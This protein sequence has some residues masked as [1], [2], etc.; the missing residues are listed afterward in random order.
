[1]SDNQA[2]TRGLTILN[3]AYSMAPVSGS[4]AGGAEQIVAALDRA[5]V[6]AGCRSIVIAREGSQTCGR[7]VATPASPGVLDEASRAGAAAAQR[8]AIARVLREEVVDVVH[9]H[10]LDFATSLPLAG[11]PVLATLHL[12]LTFY[13]DKTLRRLHGERAFMHCVSASQRASSMYALSFL[14]DIPNGVDLDALFPARRK[15]GFALALGR[16]CPEKGFHHALD[17]AARA[18]V[19]LL[20]AGEVFRY[21][22][23]ERYFRE[24]IAPRLGATRRFIGPLAPSRK[25]RLLAAARCLLVPSLVAETSSL[26]AMEALACGTPVIAFANGALPELIEHGRTGFIVNDSAEMARAIAHASE[27]DPRACRRAA[28]SRFDARAMIARYFATYARLARR[29]AAVA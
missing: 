3:V 18:D 21:P 9:M 11:P 27:L 16:V 29:P 4:V 14:P 25:R 10:G 1:M 17:A 15:R 6:R 22:E 23:H 26:V 28:E 7:L 5:L 13:A 24:Q 12:P 8:R 20:L 19:P 2:D